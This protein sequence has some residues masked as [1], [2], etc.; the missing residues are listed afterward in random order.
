MSFAGSI[1]EV[2]FTDCEL[3]FG[4][5]RD[6]LECAEDGCCGNDV[7]DEFIVASDEHRQ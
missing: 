4:P 1:G 6:P 7:S 5:H 2:E 3:G